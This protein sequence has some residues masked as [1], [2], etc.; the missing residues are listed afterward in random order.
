MKILNI[1][2]NFLITLLYIILFNYYLN[3][4]YRPKDTNHFFK[5]IIQFII[6]YFICSGSFYIVPRY[7]ISLLLLIIMYFIS[8]LFYNINYKNSTFDLILLIGCLI[9][10]VLINILLCEIIF[11][12]PYNNQYLS[13]IN[14]PKIFLNILTAYVLY[15]IISYYLEHKISDFKFDIRIFKQISL[16]VS[17]L[18]II[19]V[20]ISV[21]EIFSFPRIS[22]TLIFTFIVYNAA[23]I[24]F[25]R[26][27]V[28]HEKIERDMLLE[29]QRIEI[30]KEY[31]EKKL[32][33]DQ[34]IRRLRHDLKNAYVVLEGHLNAGEYDE[35]KKFVSQHTNKLNRASAM[36]HSGFSAIDSIIED[37]LVKIH[38][39]HIIYEENLSH[40][41]IGNISVSDIAMAIGLALDN[42]V[43]ATS[44]VDGERYIRVNTYKNI[45]YLI[46]EISNSIV[47]GSC[48]DFTKTSKKIDIQNHGFGVK[49]IDEYIKPYDGDKNY[50]VLEDRV[51]LRMMLNTEKAGS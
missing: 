24:F 44:Q 37:K 42:A 14:Y 12:I 17:L 50:T 51:E 32:Q 22:N 11:K 48:P 21:K 33:S 40:M 5:Y 45:N 15:I 29:K 28:K 41:Y 19:F 26:Y 16:L 6:F 2:I 13:N 20:L 35:A 47:P 34:E 25:D 43:E 39:N 4:K 10:N 36:I 49:G 18:Y 3:N 9:S 31:L 8:K 23:M 7:F 27:Q 1:I 38:E 46:I 30:E